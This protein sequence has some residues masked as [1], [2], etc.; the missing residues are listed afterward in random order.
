MAREGTRSQT[1]HS[2]PRV[3][4]N[5]ETGPT[6]KRTKPA[7]SRKTKAVPR[8]G[9]PVGVSK[10]AAPAKK[11]SVA[12]KVSPHRLRLKSHQAT[13]VPSKALKGLRQ[14]MAPSYPLLGR[15]GS[16]AFTYMS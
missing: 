12:A 9:K 6:I 13:R 8:A 7:A 15:A 10:K 11:T 3:F 5:V 1:G 14:D 2:K 4:T 16:A